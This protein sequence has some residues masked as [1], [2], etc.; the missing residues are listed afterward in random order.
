MGLGQS[1]CNECHRTYDFLRDGEK[2]CDVCKQKICDDC[3][4]NP[5]PTCLLN[6]TKRVCKD[7]KYQFKTY[8]CCYRNYCAD[9][10]FPRYENK[11]CGKEINCQI[12]QKIICINCQNTHKLPCNNE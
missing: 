12:C 2:E 3:L 7:C 1:Q 6:H 11:S 9:E 4:Q 10:K 8:Q 5:K